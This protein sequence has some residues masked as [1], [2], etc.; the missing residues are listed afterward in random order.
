MQMNAVQVSK[1]PMM[2]ASILAGLSRDTNR[3]AKRLMHI[4]E[5]LPS[6]NVSRLA[7]R[8]PELLLTVSA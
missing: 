8:Q 7:T 1:M 4:K 3:V 2:K 5:M 6:A